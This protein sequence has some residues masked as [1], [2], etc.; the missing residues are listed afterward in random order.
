MSDINMCVREYVRQVL[1]AVLGTLALAA[2]IAACAQTTPAAKPTAPAGPAGQQSPAPGTN[3]TAAD[4]PQHSPA[5][6][7]AEAS[8][9]PPA[10]PAGAPV[11]CQSGDPFGPLALT[12]DEAATRHGRDARTLAELSSSKQQPIEV[13]GPEGETGLLLQLT[14]ADGSHPL[15]SAIDA[16]RARSGSVGMGGRCGRIVDLYQVSCP[17]QSYELYMDM[18]FCGPGEVFSP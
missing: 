3:A 2:I 17:E 14:C 18:Y 4:E 12:E 13:C 11:D 15:G 16:M 1:P 7:P 6:R 5:P 10:K 8:A 9:K